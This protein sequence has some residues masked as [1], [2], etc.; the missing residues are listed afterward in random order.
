V[1]AIPPTRG[2][3]SLAEGYGCQPASA[4][5]EESASSHQCPASI[6]VAELMLLPPTSF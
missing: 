2:P 6:S 5:A 1:T 3:L 4:P